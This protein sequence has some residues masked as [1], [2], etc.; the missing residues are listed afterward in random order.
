MQLE[1]CLRFRHTQRLNVRPRP[2]NAFIVKA[3]AGASEPNLSTLLTQAFACL[4]AHAAP[5]VS[6]AHA[7]TVACALAFAEG[8]AAVMGPCAKGGAEVDVLSLARQLELQLASS[9]SATGDSF[10]QLSPS[11]SLT[12]AS[13]EQHLLADDVLQN[14][15]ASPRARLA[16]AMQT[17][18]PAGVQPVGRMRSR[19]E[20]DTFPG[21]GM[22]STDAQWAGSSDQ[23]LVRLRD[24]LLV[25]AMLALLSHASPSSDGA[26]NS[27]SHISNTNSPSHS[28][29][30]SHHR[31]SQGSAAATAAAGAPP[32]PSDLPNPVRLR[33]VK[34]TRGSADGQVDAVVN[35]VAFAARHC[36][37]AALH[38]VL[39]YTEVLRRRSTLG[40][41]SPEIKER[42]AGTQVGCRERERERDQRWPF[43]RHV[44]LIAAACWL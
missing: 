41:L 42:L 1:L 27:G 39:W 17:Q 34:V 32:S 33:P 8:C 9:A 20:R 10:S 15:S 30:P 35:P 19:E 37:A 5:S 23:R 25:S 11:H 7:G 26:P 38:C 36:G 43:L 29:S 28:T 2:S 24:A 14:L 18:Q 12:L 22:V 6:D 21:G 3:M 13:V 16:A 4:A 40:R 44:A 31:N